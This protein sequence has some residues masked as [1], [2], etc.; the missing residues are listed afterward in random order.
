MQQVI[1]PVSPIQEDF[2]LL[3]RKRKYIKSKTIAKLK[4]KQTSIA[5]VRTY[6]NIC[7]LPDLP[8]FSL[9][10]SFKL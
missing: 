1:R 3:G 5:T 10:T 6:V 2:A 9:Q 4:D 8:P 7:H